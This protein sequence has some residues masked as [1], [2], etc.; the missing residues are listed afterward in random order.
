MNGLAALLRMEW[1]GPPAGMPYASS[2]LQHCIQ[3]KSI[4]EQPT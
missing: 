3:N 1:L 4:T 2:T